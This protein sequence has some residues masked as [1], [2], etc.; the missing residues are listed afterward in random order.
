[1]SSSAFNDKQS[2]YF[3]DSKGNDLLAAV[4]TA[5]MDILEH[6]GYPDRSSAKSKRTYGDRWKF[7]LLVLKEFLDLS[8]RDLAAWLP[9]LSGV[10]GAGRV[11]RVPHHTTLRKYSARVPD[12][13]IDRVI[14]E[15]ARFLCGNDS[16][17]AIDATGFSESN[18]S[19]HFVK[20]LKYFGTEDS[21]V[22][23]FAKATL[24][25]DVS[26]KA[27]AV[28]DVVTSNTADV[29]RFVPVAEKLKDTGIPV[30]VILAD[31]GYDAEY[32]H[33]EAR[34]IFGC[35]I[36]TQIP[37]R[38]Y[39]TVK[40]ARQASRAAPKGYHRRMMARSLDRAIYRFRTI[41]ATAMPVR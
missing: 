16:I 21:V 17:I 22:R 3:T 14:G 26:S 35:G 29:K 5:A 6:L 41:V 15:S 1:M 32:V 7:G 30:S 33:L 20:R 24:A 31:K 34:R 13:L 37:A 40:A 8:Y 18:A 12:G 25:V 9:S 19:K 23:D 4:V 36:S 28:C 10:M 38:D 39:D 11:E 27:I 2:W